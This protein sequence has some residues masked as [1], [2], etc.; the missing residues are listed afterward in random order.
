MDS[1]SSKNLSRLTPAVADELISTDEA[2]AAGGS[3]LRKREKE[4]EKRS[5]MICRVG[6]TVDLGIGFN[7]GRDSWLAVGY[8]FNYY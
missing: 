7:G 1:T 6:E 5:F 8:G 2:A 4:P 3:S